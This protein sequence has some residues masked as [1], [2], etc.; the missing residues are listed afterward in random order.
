MSK[1][2]LVY[3]ADPMCSW[4][5]GFSPSIQAISARYGDTL[6]LRLV[7]GGL[8]PWTR[9]PMDDLA[10]QK[11][12]THWEHVLEASGQAFDFRFFDRPHFVYDTE[13]AS[14]AIVVMR[15]RGMPTAMAALQRIQQAFYAKNQDV[16][17]LDTL[18]A[19]A[20][21]LGFGSGAFKTDFDSEAARAET[22]QDF[23]LTQSTGIRG[24]PALIA[25]ADEDKPF[26][27]IAQGFQPVERTLATLEDWFK[28]AES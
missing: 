9:E 3:F 15:R 23:M 12:R 21:E 20:I 28:Q 4:C 19:I 5:W 10:R 11:T 22:R 18:T 24:F 2:Q 25:G 8:R 13:P 27:L 1:P 16:T 17:S 6:P 7:L 26:Q 14:R